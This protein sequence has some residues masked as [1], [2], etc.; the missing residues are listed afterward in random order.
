MVGVLGVGIVVFPHAAAYPLQQYKAW[1][2]EMCVILAA[3]FILAHY[4]LDVIK[5]GKSAKPL[6]NVEAF[7]CALTGLGWGL[8]IY[9]FDTQS[10][11]QL[12]FIRLMILAAAM[13]FVMSS[14]TMFVR[15]FLAYILGIGFTVI[16]FILSHDYIQQRNILLVCTFLYL[17]IIIFLAI[18]NNRRIRAATLD[19]IAVLRL[20][21]E[22]NESLEKERIFN[23]SMSKLVITDELTGIFN[24]RG[25]LNSLDV[26]VARS[27]RFGRPLSILMIDIDLFKHVNDTYGH[28]IGDT[29][30]RAVADSIQNT[31]RDT[32]ML[33]RI[34]GEEF[35]AILPELEKNGAMDAA[36]RLREC[37]EKNQMCFIDSQIPITISIGISFYRTNDDS[38][39]LL[40]RAD[41][42]L[43]VAKKNGRN[44]FE[45]ESPPL[46]N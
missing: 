13:A 3:R 11:D 35:V 7:L 17:L 18:I 1:I 23:E 2:V 15:N 28:A 9:V 27:K 16:L 40:E 42:A 30:L 46:N 19:H 34:G 41:K 29:V 25:T 33:G 20:T 10:M 31:L 5:S 39:M 43:Y 37:I 26:E 32:D 12:F 21:K 44:R 45:I 6:L 8:S 24:R 4:A 22:L 38:L 14:M 36:E